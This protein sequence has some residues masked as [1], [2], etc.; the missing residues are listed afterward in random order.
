MIK[1]YIKIAWRY[2]QR[3]KL[4]SFINI[5]GL[6]VGLAVCMLIMLY[7]AHELSFDSF[8]KNGKRI[9]AL[10]ETLSFGGNSVNCPSSS[11]VT[12]PQILQND[13]KVEAYMRMYHPQNDA[14]VESVNMPGTKFGESKLQFA[15][16]GFFNF[17]TFKLSSGNA[18]DVLSKPF[19]V[20]LSKAAAGKYFGNSNPVG[21]TLKIKTDSIAYT[22]QVTGIAENAPSNSTIDFDFLASASSLAAMPKSKA[23]MNRPG[24]GNGNFKT[25]LL[26][27]Q[28]ADS[29]HLS[30]SMKQLLITQSQAFAD[31]KIILT[32]L[33]DMH[34]KLNFGDSANIKYLKIF[35]LVAGLILLLALVNYMSLS[36]ARSTLRSKEI[37]VRKVS[38]ASR[39]SIASQF[40]V[41]SALFAVLS[42]VLAYCICYFFK[43]AFLNVLQLKID[44]SFLYNPVIIAAMLALLTLTILIAGSYPS[45]VLSAF[46][47][48]ATLKGKTSRQTGGIAVRK[49]FT[50]LQFAISVALI[51]CGIIIDRQ[52]YYFRHTDTGLSRDNVVMVPIGKNFG[53]HYLSFKNDV[54]SISGISNVGTA[55]YPMYKGYGMFSVEPKNKK[56]PQLSLRALT[57]DA[58]LVKTL[59]IQWKNKPAT[60]IGVAKKIILNEAA[61]TKLNLSPVNAVGSYVDFGFDKFEVV[62]IMKDFAYSSLQSEIEPLGL[63][64]IDNK[65]ADWGTAGGCLFARIQ[66]H[67]NVPSTIAAIQNLYKKYDQE[68]PFNYIF[69]DDAFNAQYKAEDRLASIFGYFTIVTIFLASMGLFGLAA[70]TIEQRTKEIGI[71]KIL[72]AGISSITKTL[73]ADFLKLVLIAILIASPIAWWLMNSWLQGFAYRI[74]VQW[75]MFAL[76]GGLA[77]F[78][79]FITVSYQALRAAIANPVNS[80]RND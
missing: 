60:T 34:F 65:I 13:A 51:I 53:K 57:A 67:T 43:N 30:R 4:Y 8:H 36:T 52:L 45:I 40:Y 78:I 73:S 59:D 48:V 42:F 27:K 50:V 19:S 2:L 10:S 64:I 11:Y 70:F 16:A 5:S 3:H 21:K 55:N 12:G 68:T 41:E 18:A 14:I 31:Q 39:K 47:P 56:D 76:A 74:H 72:G 46:N 25:Y 15:D 20:V 7:V 71:R 17:F 22:Y 29:A 66:P 80:L 69:M 75:W 44:S 1:N 79:A 37:G 54:Q 23:E 61:V 35:P 58:D 32:G 33:T 24:I 77:I 26:L 62:G 6:A 28:P 38:G 9:Y 49:V 63:F